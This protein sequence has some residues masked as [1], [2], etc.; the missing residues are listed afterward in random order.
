M[1]GAKGTFAYR[2]NDRGQIVGYYSD[3]SAD[4]DSA[5][6][7]RGFLLDRGRLTRIDVPGA[8]NTRPIGIDNHGQIAGSY[9]DDKRAIH[10]FLRDRNGSFTTIDVPG[11]LLTDVFDINDRGQMVGI[12]LDSGGRVHGFRRDRSGA[13]A[14]IDAPG[15]SLNRARGINN[16]GQVAIDGIIRLRHHSF[17]LDGGRYTEIKPP[18]AISGA[19]PSDIDDRGRVVGGFDATALRAPRRAKSARSAVSRGPD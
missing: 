9:I 13:I 19:T 17:V 4:P 10:G 3:T 11:A 2:I 1:P 5:P 8:S 14:T 16:R 18:G 7:Q 6:D 15:T 12:Y